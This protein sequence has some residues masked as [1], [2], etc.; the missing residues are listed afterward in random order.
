MLTTGLL[1]GG[2]ALLG[3]S[4]AARA[5]ELAAW[6]TNRIA[7][8]GGSSSPETQAWLREA[9]L[10]GGLCWLGVALLG[11]GVIAWWRGARIRRGLERAAT[12]DPARRVWLMAAVLA[13]AVIARYPATFVHGYFRY[14]DFELLAVAARVPLAEAW[15]LPHGDH[16]LPLTR[17]LA[18]AALKSFGVTAWPYNLALLGCMTA[19]LLLGCVLLGAWGVSRAAQTLFAGLLLFWSPWAELMAGYYVLATYLLVVL[20]SLTMAWCF[21]RRR[22]HPGARWS[23][24][25]VA[26]AWV[27]P[28]IDVSGW[29]VPA[30]AGVFALAEFV[31]ERAAGR[32]RE[33]LRRSRG[34]LTGVLLVSAVTLACTV[35]AYTVLH[36]GTFL[37]M[38][39][40]RGRSL[41]RLALDVGYLFDAGLLVSMVM[42][43]VYARLPLLVLAGLATATLVVWLWFTA[44]ALRRAEPAR[45][46]PLVVVLLVLAGICLMVALGR[47]SEDGIVVRWAAKHVGPAYVWLCLG[48]ALSWDTLG[49]TLAAPAGR[50]LGELTVLALVAFGAAQTL[51]AQLG[52]A[53]AFPPFG[54]PAEIRDAERRR[55]AV[56]ELRHVLGKLDGRPM[57]I[58]TLDGAFLQERAVSLFSYNLSHYEPFFGDAAARLRLVRNDVMQTWRTQWVETVPSLRASVSA[59]FYGELRQTPELR[60]YYFREVPLRA[61][62]QESGGRPVGL[63]TEWRSDG[64]SPL[65]IKREAWDPET[66]SCLRLEI[67]A[68]D[69]SSLA[70]V[71]LEVVLRS[72]LTGSDWRGRLVMKAGRTMLIDLQ[73]VY[74]CSLSEQVENLRVVLVQPGHYRVRAEVRGK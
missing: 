25:I 17:L 47:P 24:G 9:D 1:L 30:A 62:A 53:V 11:C 60:D 34:L 2:V 48:I 8:A 37:S 13:V 40:G 27:A 33:W 70:A 36:P 61:E 23:W 73:Q 69:A 54:Y 55:A 63:N 44:E 29:Y 18:F 41:V 68:A 21:V 57:T 22:T 74:A 49:R 43:F 10:A 64:Q 46:T 39:Q 12:G 38:G 72:G 5:W 58:P 4:W 65:T 59:E 28:L 31:C 35:Y 14:D 50:R 67:E 32:G 7:A 51:V 56:D 6:L 26:C 19:V 3:L 71:P 45:R 16:F 52:R 15:W 20:T 66:M 42:P